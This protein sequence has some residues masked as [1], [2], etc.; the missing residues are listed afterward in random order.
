[1]PT[2]TLDPAVAARALREVVESPRALA[3]LEKHG[4][5]TLGDV[6]AKGVGSLHGIVGVG[7]AS[8]ALIDRALGP[9]PTEKS[10]E[11]LSIEEGP[12][13]LRLESPFPQFRIL[14]VPAGRVTQPGGGYAIEESLFVEF[15][16]NQGALSKEAFLMRKFERDRQKVRDA[17]K[18]PKFPW[19]AEAVEWLKGRDSFRRH[20]FR[21]LGD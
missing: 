18:D 6:A 12:H 3:A 8:I 13:A 16:R 17:M 14:I 1:M 21:I 15:D 7:E 11:V 10:E 2:A 20:E 5:K 19:R 9:I 4:F